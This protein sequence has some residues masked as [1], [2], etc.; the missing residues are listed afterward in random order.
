LTGHTDWVWAVATAALPDGRVVAVTG[1][2]DRTVRIWDLLSVS[3]ATEDFSRHLAD[4]GPE[5]LGAIH[6]GPF[7]GADHFSAQALAKV[8]SGRHYSLS[9]SNAQRS[10]QSS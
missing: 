3:A 1:S 7:C 5:I 4:L 2:N 10:L 8:W 6:A 9:R